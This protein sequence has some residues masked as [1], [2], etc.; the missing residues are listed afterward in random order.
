MQ[1]MTAGAVIPLIAVLGLLAYLDPSPLVRLLIRWRRRY[2]TVRTRAIGLAERLRIVRDLAVIFAVAY[3]TGTAVMG[4][5][6][7]WLDE[8]GKAPDIHI[9]WGLGGFFGSAAA[10]LVLAAVMERRKTGRYP[11]LPRW[12][13]IGLLLVGLFCAG[14]AWATR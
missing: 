8:F 4:L 7:D 12:L 5:F 11:T 13:I 10:S 3:S 9:G 14:A 2:V 1:A 6:E